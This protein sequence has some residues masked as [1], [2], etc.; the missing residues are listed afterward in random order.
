MLSLAVS[1]QRWFEG[2][3][4]AEEVLEGREEEDE[5]EDEEEE[6]EEEEEEEEEGRASGR[7][8]VGLG[9]MRENTE[10]KRGFKPTQ[11]GQ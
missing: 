3:C 4:H 2:Y 5:E 8:A 1:L 7:G 6:D 11:S 9:D 10:V